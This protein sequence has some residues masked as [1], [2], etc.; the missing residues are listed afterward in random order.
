MLE[1]YGVA[2][3]LNV[4]MIWHKVAE[5]GA[6]GEETYLGGLWRLE[7]SRRYMPLSRAMIEEI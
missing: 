7:H 1:W 6:D 4:S 2:E 5:Y 3:A